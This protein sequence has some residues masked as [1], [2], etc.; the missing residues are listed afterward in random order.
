MRDWLYDLVAGISWDL[1][2]WQQAAFVAV[3]F[4][5]LILVMRWLTR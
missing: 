4:L 3:V 1:A 2:P 5:L